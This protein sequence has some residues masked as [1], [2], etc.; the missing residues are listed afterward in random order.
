MNELTARTRPRHLIRSSGT[1]LP[2]L[3][4]LILSLGA[5]DTAVAAYRGHWT[6]FTIDAAFLGIFAEI[7]NPF[8]RVSRQR[9]QAARRQ[10][11]HHRDLMDFIR[12]HVPVGK[13]AYFS[14]AGS[15]TRMLVVIHSPGRGRAAEIV[16]VNA[17]HGLL[18]DD[19]RIEI[20]TRNDAKAVEHGEAVT[21]RVLLLARPL[22]VIHRRTDGGVIIP[23]ADGEPETVVVPSTRSPWKGWKSRYAALATGTA[24]AEDWE[25]AD[26]LAQLRAGEPVRTRTAR[27]YEFRHRQRRRHD[28]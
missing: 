24:Y 11:A 28:T 25:A 9:R 16:A 12:A 19:R 1:W 23:G 6:T 8:S 10:A 5:A 13:V 4:T 7:L 18:L 26:F 17:R 27:G 20:A 22:T 2:L 3:S 15:E 14:V 21:Q